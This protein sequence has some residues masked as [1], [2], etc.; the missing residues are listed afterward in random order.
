[1]NYKFNCTLP[2]AC[3]NGMMFFFPNESQQ[4]FWMKDTPEP[5]E[6]A[7][8]NANGVVTA[9]YNAT[10]NDTTTVCHEGNAVL[11]LYHNISE[12]VQVGD[13]LPPGGI[14]AIRDQLVGKIP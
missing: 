4:C 1:M 10:P 9:V 6:Q 13:Y 5:L 14:S 12:Q 2:S 8:F 11:E 3:I 7:W